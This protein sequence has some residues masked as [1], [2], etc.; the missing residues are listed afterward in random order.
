MRKKSLVFLLLGIFLISFVIAEDYSLEVSTLKDTFQ[1]GEKISIKV[2]VYDSEGKLVNDNVDVVLQDASKTTMVEET[3]T[4]NTIQE[5]EIGE[6]ASY[7]QGEIIATYK[8]SEAKGTFT[9]EIEEL[10]KFEIKDENLIITNIGNTQYTKTV[11]ITIGETTGVKQPKLN[12]GKSISYKLVAPEGVYNIKITDG[13]TTLTQGDIKLTGTGKVI[14]ALDQTASSRSP[15]TGGISPDENSEEA[16]LSY[17]K[18]SKF[19]YT[20]V[21]VIFGAMVLLAIERRYSK[22][23]KA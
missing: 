8:E 20:F 16:L 7:G 21:L 3:I 1:Q 6:K 12:P 18:N 22:K 5:I 14:G 13:K 17:V 4:S 19:V 15:V 23:A 10:V 9:I 2:T 11:Q